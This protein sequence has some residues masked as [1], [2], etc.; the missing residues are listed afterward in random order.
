MGMFKILNKYL[1]NKKKEID[2][3]CNELI[4]ESEKVLTKANLLFENTSQM[5]ETQEYLYIKDQ[6][7]QLLNKLQNQNIKKLKKSTY[8]LTLIQSK[9]KIIRFNKQFNTKVD[10]HN[11]N[12][13]N[14]KKEQAYLLIGKV[15]G[16]KLDDQQMSCI[17]KDAHNHLIIAGAGTG[18]TT[19]IVGKIKYLLKSNQCEPEDIL[20]LS[21]T[22]A[23]A[24]EM[25][26]RIQK[27]TGYNIMATTFHKLGL[28][29]IRNVEGIYPIITK[30]NLKKFISSQLK[31]LLTCPK[32]THL[33]KKYFLYYKVNDQSEFEFS[34]QEEYK[35]YLKLNPPITFNKETV[36]SYGEMDIANFLTENNVEYIYEHP[37]KIDTRTHEYGQYYPD[38][39]LP[40]YD[41]YIEYFGINRNHQVPDY[42]HGNGEKT[43][44][45]SYNEQIEWKRQ[46]HQQNNT[47]LIECYA[48][49]KFEGILLDNL[50]Q[51][52]L[53][54][55]VQ[56]I[57]KSFQEIWQQEPTQNKDTLNGLIEL[58]E[59]IINL[60]KSN[61]YTIEDLKNISKKKRNSAILVSLLEPIYNAYCSYLKEHGEIDFND[62]INTA[63][64]YLQEGKYINPYNYVIV[65][66]YQDISKARY[67][68]LKY[69]RNSKDF[70]LF[71]VGDDWQSIYRFAG[72]DINF[73]LNFE[74]YWGKTAISKIETTY[75]F[76]KSL[77]EISG[78]FVMKNPRQIKKS[79][80]GKNTDHRFALG[81]IKA[82]NN[83][84]AS[85]FM[86]QKLND[87]P[88]DSSVFLLG[89]YSSDI[90]LIKSNNLY[91]YCYNN[92]TGVIDVTYK[93]RDDLKICF[94][95]AHKSKGLQADY[96]F[97]INNKNSKMGFPSKIQDAPIINLLLE[98]EDQYP[99]AEERRLYYVA[100]TRAKK[101]VFTVVI[102]NQ[103]SLFVKEL[104]SSYK[105]ELENERY[106]CP[107]CGGRL[108]KKSGP[109]GEFLGCSNY[110]KLD[111]RYK[112][113][114]S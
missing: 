46:L 52:L 76:S 89:R 12:I 45:E 11:K 23:S 107:Q 13:E 47:T 109:Y 92:V 81:E 6:L 101:K 69:M 34:N 62:M 86:S 106:E 110:S 27:E 26:E 77:I 73:I 85:E 33:L 91:S 5:I 97:I 51:Q 98:N 59:T 22:N 40:Q 72:S 3:Q 88:K 84:Y 68:L 48:Y 93:K 41:I 75:R 87:L 36:K 15:E 113:K 4:K 112:R 79:I 55:N 18:K 99:Y 83:F 104:E 102:K 19:T 9:E 10:L 66:E 29:I 63:S 105:K 78:K 94:L 38:F 32:Y 35:E 90:E 2:L 42:F 20:V 44:S 16:Q 57:S 74:H 49:E 53:S 30:I 50:K 8:Y 108:F 24:S 7:E 1:N 70:D 56:L 67:L 64:K 71:C 43:A 111:C 21:F 39:Y 54:Y 60:T 96:V 25:N 58:F 103:E 65:D 114:L 37:Y 17:V 82:V 31:Q 100:L 80:Q 95:T 28:D 14:I 61:N